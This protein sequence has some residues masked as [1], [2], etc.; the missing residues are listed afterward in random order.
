[1]SFPQLPAEAAQ[2]GNRNSRLDVPRPLDTIQVV[3]VDVISYGKNSAVPDLIPTNSDYRVNH[4]A[5]TRVVKIELLAWK[6]TRAT[7][8]PNVVTGA[9]RDNVLFLD[10]NADQSS[11]VPVDHAL[12]LPRE[13]QVGANLIMLN[14]PPVSP[15][16][17]NS[18]IAVV[19]VIYEEF[20]TPRLIWS[21]VS[22]QGREIRNIRARLLRN[23]SAIADDTSCTTLVDISIDDPTKGLAEAA[24]DQLYLW[25]RFHCRSR[26]AQ[27]YG[28]LIF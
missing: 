28:S 24:Y 8:N 20:K 21:D 5:F 1:M 10:L 9:F 7:G 11:D 22:Q 12:I 2:A 15:V 14:V 19:P 26:A 25:L 6:A 3:D 23:S 18:S 13:F 16:I 27:S 4:G 17:P